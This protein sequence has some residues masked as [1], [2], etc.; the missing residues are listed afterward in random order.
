M[1]VARLCHQCAC[2]CRPGRAFYYIAGLAR[3]VELLNRDNENHGAPKLH[4]LNSVFGRIGQFSATTGITHACDKLV[5]HLLGLKVL[6]RGTKPARSLTPSTMMPPAVFAKA[7]TVSHT[8]RESV[9]ALSLTS[10]LRSSEPMRL[11]DSSRPI[12]SFSFI[13]TS[14]RSVRRRMPRIDF[15]RLSAISRNYLLSLCYLSY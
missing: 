6:N 15:L 14:F 1:K 8:S 10:T 5:E 9:V 12:S 13:C 7:L 3:R 2:S 11:K 4:A